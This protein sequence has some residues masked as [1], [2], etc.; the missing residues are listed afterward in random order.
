MMKVTT[1]PGG[2]Q[3]QSG[4]LAGA[5]KPLVK[6]VEVRLSALMRVEY[7]EVVEVPA[8]I[9]QAEIDDLVNTRYRQVDGGDYTR[10]PEYWAR[11]ACEVVDSEMP[12]AT[13][14]MMA[15]RTADGLHV[16]RADS[17]SQRHESTIDG[18][19]QFGHNHP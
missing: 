11:G 1:L 4:H 13:P 10:D 18:L 7:M 3:L 2:T 5:R 14:T 9:T 15:F 19:C 6:L 8:N 17:A 12:G 16:E